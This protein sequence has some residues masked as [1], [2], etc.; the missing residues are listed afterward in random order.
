MQVTDAWGRL[1]YGWGR[2]YSV[3]LL[4]VSFFWRG[5]LLLAGAAAEHFSSTVSSYDLPRS[6][7][8]PFK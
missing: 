6:S 2:G 8:V 3:E 4:L 1:K 5:P 7:Q